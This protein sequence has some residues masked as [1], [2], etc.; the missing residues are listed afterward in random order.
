[1]I[2][3]AGGGGPVAARTLWIIHGAFIWSMPIYAVLARFIARGA[4]TG[5]GV[6][7]SPTIFVAVIVVS[8]LQIFL[9][10]WIPTLLESIAGRAGS[11]GASGAGGSG[12]GVSGA[13]PSTLPDGPKAPDVSRYARP[14]VVMD[15]LME[16][17]AVYG[18]L[19]AVVGFLEVWQAWVVMGLGL[20]GL[21]A[22]IPRVRGWTGNGAP[23]A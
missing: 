2:A 4:E 10:H 16:A 5:S 20:L 23:P 9:A 22:A 12:M 11:A 8:L 6:S 21:L 14:L 17:V 3:P 15:A 7:P 13:G 1:M 18:L 19:G